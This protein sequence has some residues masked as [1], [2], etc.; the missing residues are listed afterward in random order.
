MLVALPA[1][2][3]FGVTVNAALGPEHAARGAM[4]GI[5]GATV[6]GLVA[7]WL[8]GTDRLISAPCAPAAA[9]LSAFAIELVHRGV[10]ADAIAS[11]LVLVGI[12]GGL[13]QL[14]LGLIG[15]GGLIRY[16]PYP[17]VS[18]Y[19]TAVGLIIIG[20]QIPKFL[21]VP[22]RVMWYDALRAPGQWDLRAIGIAVTTVL[23]AVLSPRRVRRVPGIILGILAGMV[24]FLALVAFDPTLRALEHNPLVIGPFDLDGGGLLSAVTFRWARFDDLGAASTL[25]VLGT[26]A[27]LGVL[28]SIDTLKTCVVLDRITRVRHDSNRELLGQGVANMTASA[29]G[30]LSGAGQMAATLVGVNGGS[31]S[32]AAGIIEGLWALLAALLLRQYI[33]W[34]PVSALAGILVVIG[35]RM[36]DREPLQFLESRE[37]FLDF[38][39]VLVVV[40]VAL[41][42]SLIAASAVGVALAMILFVRE[43]IGTPVVRHKAALAQT[44]SSW[45]R[46]EREVAVLEAQGDQAIVFELQGSLFFGNAYQLYGDLQHEVSTRRYVVIDLRR[47]RSIDVT[48]AQLFRQ[49]RDTIRER[50]A[51]LVFSGVRDQHRS[52]RNLREFLG[53]NGVWH[54]D[55]TTVRIFT[56]LDAAVGWVEDRILGGLERDVALE[57]P[58]ELPE[59]EI[60]AQYQDDTIAELASH[61]DTRRFAA[62]EMIYARGTPGDELYWVRRGVVRNVAAIEANRTVPVAT[63]GRGDVFGGLAFMDSKPRPHD[64]I[65]LTDT[66]L[67]VLTREHFAQLASVHHRLAFNLANEMARTF[68]MRLRRAERKISMLQES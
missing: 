49:I 18:G 48:A 43:Q 13:I 15:L 55:S 9:V 8:G 1:S 22:G 16:I 44:S 64:A 4:A 58:M 63:F 60:F 11:L 67:Y 19:L 42:S 46:P 26:A 36:I 17:V 40:V 34:I 53:Q 41:T 14:T 28:L 39:V 35:V 59:M 62:G 32:S 10:P 5:V 37:T 24:A 29:L 31:R 52:G 57:S 25:S 21:G 61:M 45:H 7:S 2:I 66:E 3:A 33:A 6:V 23:V 54:P 20:G 38:V 27:T 65:A 56:D 12:L 68:A 47:V 30:G 51:T 50:G